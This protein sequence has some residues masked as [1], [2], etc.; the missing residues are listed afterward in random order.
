MIRRLFFLLL[1]LPLVACKKESPTRIFSQTQVL[2][3]GVQG[4]QTVCRVT[5]SGSWTLTVAGKD[6]DVSPQSG[7]AGETVLT[8]TTVNEN[9]DAR[10]RAL[11]TITLR[12]DVAGEARCIEVLQRPAI[13]PR[14]FFFFFIGTSLQWFFDKNLQDALS[15]IDAATPGDGRVAAF[16]YNAAD[17]VWEI[18]ELHYDP[19][20]GSAAITTV[21]QFA[22]IDRRDPTFITEIVGKMLSYFPAAEYGLAFGG[23]G[24]GWLPIGSVLSRMRSFSGGGHPVTRYYGEPGSLF[25]VE[26]I[27]RSL[28]AAGTTFDYLCFDDCFMSN[29]ET[30]YS[31]RKSARYIIASPCE[32]MG[33]GFPYQYVIPAVFHASAPLFDRLQTVCERY[34]HYYLSEY[35]PNYPSG[36][37]ALTDCAQLDALAQA[38]Q[39]LFATA[40]DAYDPAQLQHYEGLSSHIFFDFLQYAEQTATDAQA[41]GSVREQFDFAFPP[42]C[43]FHTPSFYSYYQSPLIPVTYYSGV[44]CSAPATRYVAENRQTEWWQATHP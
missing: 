23:H 36:C 1:L 40:S 22:Q 37:I 18:A 6:F 42:E 39:P 38:A 10:R 35:N 32:V 25:E 2:L 16:R 7:S 21:E 34:Y 8:F 17:K 26:E 44:T 9:T 24:S 19:A 33:E 3:E 4:A 12:P 15:A 11:G 27:A 14:S 5:A 28:A 43:R 29:I 13:A 30:L 20:S 41:L 31:L